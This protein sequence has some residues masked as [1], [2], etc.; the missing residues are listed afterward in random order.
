MSELLT[1]KE[2]ARWYQRLLKENARGNGGALGVTCPFCLGK[3]WNT[4]CDNCQA[5]RKR[6]RQA[7]T[8]GKRGDQTLNTRQ[9]ARKI[10]GNP[11]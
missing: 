5:E 4:K 11:S 7:H 6:W 2:R 10:H 9:V 8:G 1:E 3:E